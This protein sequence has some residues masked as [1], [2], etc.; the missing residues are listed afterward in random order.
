MTA[1]V[2]LAARDYWEAARFL[3]GHCPIREAVEHAP[4]I[5][6]RIARTA[7]SE[8]VRN[9]AATALASLPAGYDGME[10]I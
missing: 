9:R 10:T 6:A 5:L 4:C 7:S 8:A 2:T 1:T 3:R